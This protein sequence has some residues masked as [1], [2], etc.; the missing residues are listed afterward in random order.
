[1][2]ALSAE[3]LLE[4]WERGTQRTLPERALAFLG[5]ALPGKKRGDLAGLTVG[6][7]DAGLLALRDRSLGPD[8]R[9]RTECPVCNSRLEFTLPIRDIYVDIV[10]EAPPLEGLFEQDGWSL[11]YRL[12]TA[13][14]LTAATAGPRRDVATVRTELLRRTILEASHDGAP[15]PAPDLLERLP[16]KIVAALGERMAA[17]DPQAEVVLRLSCA[18]CGHGWL[19][20]LDICNFFW[21]ET[22][23]MS[24]RLLGEVHALARA[25]GWNQSEILAMSPARRQAYIER[26]SE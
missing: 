24:E 22:A 3:G 16:E 2:R 8:L 25:Y 6:E 18:R 1:V 14:D 17:D 26:I 21:S 10:E 19:A 11:R 13:G 4:V 23:A 5:A 7:R 15:I 20:Y 12:P 9:G